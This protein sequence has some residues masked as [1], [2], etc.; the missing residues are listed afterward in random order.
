M[1]ICVD[2]TK[3]LHNFGRREM[4]AKLVSLVLIVLKYFNGRKASISI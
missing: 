1:K 2:D 3:R 4:F